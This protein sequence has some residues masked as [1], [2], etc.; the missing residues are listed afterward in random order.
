MPAI[1]DIVLLNKAGVDVVKLNGQNAQIIASSVMKV[2]SRADNSA[3]TQVLL[4][5]EANKMYVIHAYKIYGANNAGT[6]ATSIYISAFD[7]ITGNEFR[8]DTCGLTANTVNNNTVR[9]SG[10]NAPT[11]PGQPVTLY[12]DVAPAYRDVVLYYSEIAV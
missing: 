1:R 5:A 12:T 10:L 3:S 7:Y 6:A 9:M 8:L 4:P 2:A 11:M